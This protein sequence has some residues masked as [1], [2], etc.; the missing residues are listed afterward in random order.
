MRL[1]RLVVE[2]TG[3]EVWTFLV[4]AP[5]GVRAWR[6]AQA[7]LPR[8]LRRSASLEELEGCGDERPGPPRVVRAWRT[9]PSRQRE[10]PS[11][12]APS[13]ALLID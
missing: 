1:W 6:T 3:P 2:L 10:A 5:S 12:E 4:V 9:A 13:L 7:S 8:R 11:D